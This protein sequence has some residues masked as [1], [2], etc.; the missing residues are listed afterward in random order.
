MADCTLY[1][2]TLRWTARV[3]S[4]ASVPRAF[5][6]DKPLRLLRASGTL[7]WTCNNGSIDSDFH[8]PCSFLFVRSNHPTPKTWMALCSV[9][10]SCKK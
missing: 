3:N 8:L 4:T 9:T 1:A 2:A 10:F 5:L 7:I 6:L